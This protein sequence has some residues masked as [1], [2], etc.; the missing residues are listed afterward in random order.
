LERIVI[1]VVVGSNPIGHPKLHDVPR[2]AQDCRRFFPSVRFRRN[3]KPRVARALTLAA[4]GLAVLLVAFDAVATVP[5]RVL[6]IHSF[7]RDFAPY[8]TIASVFRAELARGAK[9]SVAVSEATLDAGR[10]LTGKEQQAFFEYLSARFDGS[11]PD[12]VVTMG[13][14]AARFY[15][16]HRDRLFPTTPLLIAA[17]DERFARSAPLRPDDAAVLSKV[18]LPRL[19]DNIVQ[20][21]PDTRTIAV[22]IGASEL[23]RFWLAE[24]KRELA[25]LT[26]RVDFLWWNDLSLVEMQQRAG[27]LPA[28]SVIFYGL[29]VADAAG[30]PHERQDALLSLRA[31]ARAPIFGIYEEELGKG[32]VGGPYTSQR[33]A[34]EQMSA[35]ALRILDRAGPAGQNTRV[36]DFETPVYDWRELTRWKIDPSR[37]P[38]GS[39]IRFKPPSVWDE[40]RTAL[41]ATAAVVLLQ[42]TL[43]TGLLIQRTRRRQAEREAA[44]LGGRILTAQEDERRRLAREMHDDVTQRLAALAIDAAK[45]QGGAG[46]SSA[47]KA[48]SAIRDGLVKLSEDVH[49]LSYRLHP[50]VIE[51]LGLVAALRVEC[52][53]IARQESIR[54]DFESQGVPKAVPSNA[55]ACLFRVAQEALRNVVRH[56][57]AGSVGV[58]LAA[59]D[60]GIALAVRDDGRGF[61]GPA[62]DGPASLGLVS[63]RERVRLVG[64][65]LDIVSRP[66]HGT[67]VV[68]WVPLRE[69]S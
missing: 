13:P 46:T 48:A 39:E 65:R 6:L 69:A 61:S 9:A 23:E 66:G 16:A 51:D 15:L 60:G 31:V 55:A 36:V 41:I 68:A 53:R 14:P 24:L 8:D 62:H 45:V 17:L 67:S 25:P 58:S 19:F 20:L 18:D 28:H 59:K 42:A 32:V 54:V 57:N 35:E 47:G 37:L 29:L 38:P 3:G 26:S 44:H 11:A 12:L 21:L 33:R 30:I 43:I 34:G 50:S 49:A 2:A 1:P 40:H 22:V 52:N 27:D 7:G 63:M 10:A 56:A 64:G 5:K 4:I